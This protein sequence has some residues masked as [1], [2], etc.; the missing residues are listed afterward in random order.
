MPHIQGGYIIV[1]KKILKSGI[2]EKPPVYMKLWLWMLCRANYREKNNLT[3][4]EFVTN[5]KEM[6]EAMSYMVGY[7]KETPTAKEIRGAY[8]FLVK[9]SMIVTA[10]VTRGMK[11]TICN[12]SFYQDIKNYE[13]NHE[14]NH[15]GKVEGTPNNR[16]KNK[17]EKEENKH[18]K[19]L[20]DFIDPIL[21]D[22]FLEMRISINSPMTDN[23]KKLLISKISKL[24][25][26]G[27]SP[28]KLLEKAIIQNW[29]S[30]FE[31]KDTKM[32]SD[33]EA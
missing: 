16:K 17:E 29:K 24:K 1:S 14:G 7:R 20:P 31:G 28:K 15:E 5:I 18:K 22:S 13:G 10:K 19:I 27:H 6:Q 21:W 32:S 2:F 3:R 25:E 12:Y 11:I 26:Q 30:V 4:G 8:D 23:A 9:G 33:W